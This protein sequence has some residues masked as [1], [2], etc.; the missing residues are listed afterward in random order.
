MWAKSVEPGEKTPV[1]RCRTCRLI[2][3][4]VS[5]IYF[6]LSEKEQEHQ[7]RPLAQYNTDLLKIFGFIENN[8]MKALSCI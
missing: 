5:T 8:Y 3:D 2:C 1:F 4:R 7:Q 6:A